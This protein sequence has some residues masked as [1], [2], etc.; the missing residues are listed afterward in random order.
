[1]YKEKNK[2]FVF[3]KN[4]L[5]DKRLGNIIFNNKNNQFLQVNIQGDRVKMTTYTNNSITS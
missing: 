5:F 1:M 2:V 4:K 3:Y